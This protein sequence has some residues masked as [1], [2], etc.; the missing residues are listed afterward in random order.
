MPQIT[1]YIS[2]RLT[3]RQLEIARNWATARSYAIKVW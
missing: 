1:M 2:R 3:N